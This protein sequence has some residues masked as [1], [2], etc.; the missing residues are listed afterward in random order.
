[1]AHHQ[2][3]FDRMKLRRTDPP[4]RIHDRRGRPA[5]PPPA[6]AVRPA[7]LWTQ[8]RLFD[9]RPDFT[10]FDERVHADLANPWLVWAHYLAHRLGEG[11]GWR[12]GVRLAV[13]RGLVIVLSGH[14]AGDTVRYSEMFAALRARDIAT[15]RV[16]EVLKEMGVLVDDRRPAF[17]DWLERKLEGLTPGISRDVEAWQRALHDGGPR[18]RARHRATGNNYLNSVRPALVAWSCR[19]NHLREVTRDDVLAILAPLHGPRRNITLVALRSLFAFCKRNGTVFRNPTGRIK[20]GE[21]GYNVIQPLLPVEVGDAIAAATTPAARLLLALAAIHA[22]R[23][24]AIRALRL[25]D[26]DIGNRRLVIAG[27]IRPLDELTHHIL[28]GWLDHRRT[29]WPNT[30]N[31]HLIV[32]QQTALESGPVSSVWV[33]KALRGQTATLERLRVDR[34]LEEAITHGPDPLHLAAVFGIDQKTAIRYAN[35][36]RQ[37]L[38]TA[39]EQHGTD[40]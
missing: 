14:A 24:G 16:A 37:L 34:Q 2:L 11:R 13:H 8:A 5:K 9:A 39:A 31:P 4:V 7:P 10:R 3:F 1:M 25:D 33:N 27:R 26:I 38:E 12:R 32:N 20:V 40:G 21:H 22:A 15:E 23:S 36:A 35:S 29:R 17:G 30:A 18:T 28:V 19:Y 6:P